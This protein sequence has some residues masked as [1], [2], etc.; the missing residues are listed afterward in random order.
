[1]T[2]VTTSMARP[3]HRDPSLSMKE[4][5]SGAA[6]LQ[7]NYLWIMHMTYQSLLQQVLVDVCKLEGEAKAAQ[8]DAAVLIQQDVGGLEVAEDNRARMQVLQGHEQIASYVMNG[9]LWESHI[10]PQQRQKISPDTVLQDQPQVVAGLIPARQISSFAQAFCYGSSQLCAACLHVFQLGTAAC[11]DCCCTVT[12]M[13]KC[14]SASLMCV[15]QKV[16]I[17]FRH[18]SIDQQ[19]SGSAWT[20]LPLPR[21]LGLTSK[22]DR[23]HLPY[24]ISTICIR[25]F[26]PYMYA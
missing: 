10:L 26:Q 5:A 13:V 22:C 1:M 9:G 15:Q 20:R 25:Q 18:A 11:C 16:N 14:Q 19:S 4:L 17:L 23:L 7:M 12:Q 24:N 3:R 2:G 8:L 21:I 6:I